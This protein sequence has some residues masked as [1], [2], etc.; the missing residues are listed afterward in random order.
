[1]ESVREWQMRFEAVQD[2]NYFLNVKAMALSKAKGKLTDKLERGCASGSLP[3]LAESF[4]RAC[5]VGALEGRTPLLNFLLD[6]GKNL[7]SVHTHEGDGRGK[8]FHAST[9]LMFE[10]LARFGG[11]MA[12]NFALMN[13]LGPVL[14]T[15]MVEYRK[16]AFQY[17]GILEEAVFQHLAKVLSEHK[18]RLGI[19]G[20]VPIECREDETAS[21]RLA[22]WNR[23]LDVIEGFCGKL[24]AE[25][26]SHK[27]SFDC[28][29]S[30]ATYESITKAFSELKVGSMS[31]LILLNPLVK[32][33]PRLV[34]A[35]LPTCNSFDAGQVDQQWELVRS[36]HR[37]H[38][39]V[40][41]GPLIAHASD[42]DKKRVKCMVESSERGTYGP[43]VPGFTL[44]AEVLDGLPM[45]MDQDFPHGAKKGRNSFLHAT[46]DVFWGQCIA[47]KNHLRLVMEVFPRD[48]HGL[49]EEDVD[50]RDKQNFAA[51]QQIAFPKVRACL[52]KLQ[53]GYTRADG[54]YFQEDCRGTAAHL[55]MI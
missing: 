23:R 10:T 38:L 47:T 13:L 1:M 36:W 4:R 41:V 35:L 44:K 50:V 8:R 51:V 11:P 31:R 49:L 6:L 26:E 5:E 33:L 45:L 14:N 27:C 48:E 19:T 16:E 20:P 37:K 17:S 22:T 54:Q 24:A 55:E 29:P 34:Y 40:S 32:G 2:Q 39:S 18:T 12:H 9:K 21:I 28:R 3:E 15:S 25:G 30:A 52:Q 46:R 42:G 53:E 43:D 7:V